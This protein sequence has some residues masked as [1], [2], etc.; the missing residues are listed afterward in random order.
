MDFL[1]FK[2]EC[3]LS[4][5]RGLILAPAWPGFSG[6]HWISGY[7]TLPKNLVKQ[8]CFLFSCCFQ[9][10]GICVATAESD[11]SLLKGRFVSPLFAVMG[12]EPRAPS[13]L[14][15][16]PPPCSMLE[17]SLLGVFLTQRSQTLMPKVLNKIQGFLLGLHK[18]LKLEHLSFSHEESQWSFFKTQRCGDVIAPMADGLCVCPVLYPP[19]LSL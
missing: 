15:N 14:C 13:R 5:L 4:F 16:P 19:L 17:L 9:R 11:W 7:C 1:Y 8:T 2:L 6:T 18:W 3:L 10:P 12:I